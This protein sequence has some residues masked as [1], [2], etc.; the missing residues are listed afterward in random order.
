MKLKFA[1]HKN[2]IKIK[3][4]IRKRFKCFFIMLDWIFTKIDIIISN[5]FTKRTRFHY[6]ERMEVQLLPGS[7][8]KKNKLTT[9]KFFRIFFLQINYIRIKIMWKYKFRKNVKKMGMLE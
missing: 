8:R 2:K 4:K 1:Y 5:P 6:D 7:H 3:D 9:K